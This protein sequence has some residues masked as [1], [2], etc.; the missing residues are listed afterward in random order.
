MSDKK[1]DVSLK[2]FPDDFVVSTTALNPILDNWKVHK[3]ISK[4]IFIKSA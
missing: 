2:M 4:K 3:Q 1:S